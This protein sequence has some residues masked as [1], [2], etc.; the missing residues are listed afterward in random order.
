MAPSIS[1][2]RGVKKGPVIVRPFEEGPPSPRDI[3]AVLWNAYV[4]EGYT[5]P[6]VAKLKL[7]CE[8][9]LARGQVLCAWGADPQPS[10]QGLVIVVPPTSPA[11]QIAAPD[12]AE[13][14]LL[15]V[16]RAFRGAGVG[17]HL[18]RSAI[19]TAARS[20]YVRMVLRTRTTML[21]AQR[22]YVGN[23]FVR[24]EHRDAA[25]AESTGRAFLVFERGPGSATPHRS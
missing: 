17:S 5:E 20:G 23:G 22:I 13:L 16:R 25:I 19:D 18:V 4:D 6:D 7:T 15:A 2:R 3:E 21:A 1:P 14:H 8:A 9:V 24:A 11:R 12:E 10:L